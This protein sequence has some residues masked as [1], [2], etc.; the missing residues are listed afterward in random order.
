M[1]KCKLINGNVYPF[2]EEAYQSI[3]NAGLYIEKVEEVEKPDVLKQ[4]EK[5]SAKAE[6][7]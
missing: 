7:E 2:T 5:E 3:K 4:K 6:K 1:P